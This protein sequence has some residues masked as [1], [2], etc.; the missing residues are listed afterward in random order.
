MKSI[1]NPDQLRFQ[2]ELVKTRTPLYIAAVGGIVGILSLTVACLSPKINDNRFN[3]II[4]F[5]T[6]AISI[7]FGGAAGLAQQSQSS[8]NRIENVEKIDTIDLEK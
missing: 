6:T 1:L 4:N 8:N 7:G 2:I 3:S 5:A